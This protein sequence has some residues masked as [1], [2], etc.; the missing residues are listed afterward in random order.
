MSEE[1]E[2]DPGWPCPVCG[3]IEFSI[4]PAPEVQCYLCDEHDHDRKAAWVAFAAAA[5]PH[6][7]G[8]EGA[9]KAADEMLREYD[10]RFPKRRAE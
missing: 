6:T 4:E 8:A 5:W 10:V 3:R 9:A 7:I 1:T 2:K